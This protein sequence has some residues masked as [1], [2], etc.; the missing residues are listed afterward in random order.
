MLVLLFTVVLPKYIIS[1]SLSGVVRYVASALC[2]NLLTNGLVRSRDDIVTIGIAPW[3]LLKKRQ[4]FIGRDATVQYHPKA[5]STRSRFAILN[6]KHSYFLL[7][8]NGSVGRYGADII[9][10]SRL[11]EYISRQSLDNVG[12]Y[13]PVVC[14]VLEGGTCTIRSVLDYVTNSVPIPVVVCD[15]SGRAADLLAYA[16]KLPQTDGYCNVTINFSSVYSIPR[17]QKCT[18]ICERYLDINDSKLFSIY[19]RAG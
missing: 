1:L 10:R 11:E 4:I 8:D 18:R 12:R 9:L 2:E 13:V 7:V 15:G 19:C 14:V 17:F 5:F 3:G 6:D 16:H